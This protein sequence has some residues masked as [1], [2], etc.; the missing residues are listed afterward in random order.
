MAN[1]IEKPFV[2]FRI[3][4]LRPDGHPQ[5]DVLG[6]RAVL[7]TAAPV[8][9]AL[10]P[11]Q[12][13]VAIVD[14]RID[15]AISDRNDTAATAAIA[16]VRTTL[17]DIFLSPK[18]RHAVAAVTSDHLDASLVDEF[19]LCGRIMFARTNAGD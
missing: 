16:P 1:K 7:I 8:L 17:G 5:N 11:M 13:G 6:S 2:G 12:T 19:H 14:Q 4:D 3:M 10:G 18:A 15:V 9:T